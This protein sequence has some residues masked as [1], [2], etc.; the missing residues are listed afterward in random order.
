MFLQ[1]SFQIFW[2]QGECVTLISE[3]ISVGKHK[4][5]NVEAKQ[6]G[7][8]GDSRSWGACLQVANL[9]TRAQ[10]P[11]TYVKAGWAWAPPEIPA[12]G[13]GNQSPGT[14]DWQDQVYLQALGLIDRPCLQV[15]CEE[16]SKISNVKLG[17]PP[18]HK[19]LNT[20]VH[21]YICPQTIHTYTWKEEKCKPVKL[22]LATGKKWAFSFS[23][24][25][26]QL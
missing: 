18:A 10:I 23:L 3:L 15:N 5:W 21:P 16:E 6:C 20:H 11:R 17:P 19:H 2:V 12:S 7:R 24:N 26:S 9:K 13:G 8:G 4:T 22:L 25:Y 14:I 1:G